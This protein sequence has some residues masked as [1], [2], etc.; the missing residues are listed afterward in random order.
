[1][2]VLRANEI[3]LSFLKQVVSRKNLK[4][5]I[6]E[7]LSYYTSLFRKWERNES[8]DLKNP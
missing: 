1:M 8:E 6:I 5:R 7:A 3:S 4:N 2:K